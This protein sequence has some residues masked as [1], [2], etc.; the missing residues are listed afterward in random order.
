VDKLKSDL[1]N[2]DRVLTIARGLGPNPPM[3]AGEHTA[4]NVVSLDA[5]RARRKAMQVTL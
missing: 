5:A 3:L 4:P 1:A 2:I